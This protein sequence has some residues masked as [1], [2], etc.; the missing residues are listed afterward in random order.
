MA[1][2]QSND[3]IRQ[4]MSGFS[5]MQFNLGLLPMAQ[6]QS[7]GGASQQFQAPPPPP[8]IPHPGEAAMQAMS[9]H[10]DM[11]QQTLQAA[12]VTRYQPPPSA[13][14]PAVSAMVSMGAGNPFMAPPVGG[15]YSGGGGGGGF[16]GGGGYA[17]GG[18]FAG[19]GFAGGGG[20]RLPSVFNPFAPTL[21][22]AHF[23]SPAMRNLQLMQHAQSQTMGMIAGV[24]E[25]ALGIG[26]SVLGGAIGTALGGGIG[27]MIGSWAGG[28]IGGAVSSMV[29]NPVTQDFARGR[30]I[31]QMTSPFMVSGAHLNTAT[32][33]GMDAQ[34][35]RQVATG[36]RHLQR[37]YDFE[38]TGFNTQDTMRIM[39]SS[40]GAGLLTGAQNPDQI[41]QKVKDISK[42]V[43][44]LMKITGDPD[45][46]SAIHSLGE[47]RSMGFQ[48]LAAQ[49]GA[50]ANRATFARMAG[51]SQGQMGQI[52]AQGGDLAAQFGL[53]G[54]TGANAAMYGA[55]SANVAAS[56]GA[57]NDL[58]L[59]RAGG[60]QG[61]GQIT[62]AASLNAMQNEMYLLAGSKVGKGGKL[63]MDMDAFRRAQGMSFKDVAQESA[64][65][66]R[67][68][69][70]HGIFDW[71]TRKQ[72]LKDTIAQK[73]R[74]GEMQMMF[75]QQ[76]RAFQ[77]QVPGMTLG[78]ALQQTSGGTLDAG[79][80][81]ALEVQ[82]QSRQYWE[83]MAQQGRAQLREVRDH[84]KA[85]REQYRTPGMMTQAGRGIR[86]AMGAVSDTVSSPFRSI[87]EHFERVH[88]DEDA[89]EH[90]ER[91]SRYSA[92]DI[93]ND[94]TE[95]R[96]L[97]E[98]LRDPGFQRAARQ[99]RST[100]DA[101]P[102]RGSFAGV[103]G[104]SL[105]MIPGQFGESWRRSTEREMNRI[106]SFLGLS[107]ESAE[108]RISSI[109][110][111][112]RGRRTSLFESFH[113]AG[114]SLAQV[115]DVIETSKSMG[116]A[117]RLKADAVVK[118]SRGITDALG[119]GNKVNGDVILN[120]TTKNMVMAINDMKAGLIK[121]AG[122]AGASDFKAAFVKANKDAGV[123][124]DAAI[125]KAWQSQKRGIMASVSRDIMASGTK[126]QKEV[127]VKA[128]EVE[129]R[130]GGVDLLGDRDAVKAD[131]KDKLDM[132]GMGDISDDTMGKVKS[133]VLH[134]DKTTIA[135]ATALAGQ[136][137]KNKAER[138]GAQRVLDEMAQSM[139]SEAF[140]KKKDEASRLVGSMDDNTQDAFEKMLRG[141]AG[142]KGL[143]GSVDLVQKATKERLAS[144]A[145]DEFMQRLE[146]IHKGAS[147]ASS[148]AGAVQQIRDD[149]LDRME[150]A[151]G[152]GAEFAKR[153]RK[154]RDTGD[155]SHIEEDIAKA[156][157]KSTTSRHSEGSSDKIRELQESIDKQEDEAS[158]AT[159]DEDPTAK[160]Q[161]DSTD[162][163][164]KSVVEFATAVKDLK[165]G[166]EAANLA[167]ANP[168]IAAF[169][170]GR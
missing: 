69:Q 127:M 35:A 151:G 97:R 32:G 142:A 148:V 103:M 89:A 123:T 56:S 33:Q 68:L 149:E 11:V 8:Q 126:E 105:G 131:I 65:K 9:R 53:V 155:M 135:M 16:G 106:G 169:F 121:S 88:E 80:A 17:G 1:D 95:Q 92:L 153:L 29:F 136:T 129:A 100:F 156:G 21:P 109:A 91:I 36:I 64:S 150:E 37:D 12:Q 82:F 96:A 162:L 143:E 90:G 15:G 112:S 71:D 79:Q 166:G 157:P 165:G 137:S 104:G 94:A 158:K 110:D 26:G 73:L 154:A 133:V 132:S 101:A 77:A 125:E 4:M 83:G 25:A 161:S 49:A 52:M 18:A 146:G 47:M 167:A 124:D 43:K 30:Q 60:R 122:A 118:T 164:A 67:E 134:H 74:P 75:L 163:F 41:V 2:Q 19:G 85:A 23:A 87:S 38:R 170:G 144:A 72:E 70:A 102:G 5:A 108:N 51:V 66:L 139:G 57:L 42:T 63:E 138:E 147:S 78:Q 116:D 34:S 140:N 3:T 59:A 115:Q 81:R 55:G 98:G 120:N 7:M 119:T 27:G 114:E 128:Q 130:A 76:A 45:V 24:G 107:S 117:E 14:T 6:A 152:S 62:A 13:P 145:S 160:M 40:A 113:D 159:G 50:V 22:Q 84:E 54:A 48:G 99:G 168:M 20:P 141:T 58:Q 111:Y 39:Q 61:L 31:Q 86:D 93:A 28:K 46:Q 10:N 44:L